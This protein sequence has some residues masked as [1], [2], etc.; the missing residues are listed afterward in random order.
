MEQA[1]PVEQESESPST[2]ESN[3]ALAL[4]A[5]ESW[6]QPV[7]PVSGARQECKCIPG[8]IRTVIWI[9]SRKLKRAKVFRRFLFPF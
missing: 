3:I 7:P 2:G 6:H 1:E 5:S 8:E 9:S 4:H